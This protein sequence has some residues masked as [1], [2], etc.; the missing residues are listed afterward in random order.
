MVGE[1]GPEFFGSATVGAKGQ[2]VIPAGLRR[3]LNLEPGDKLIFF[4]NSEPS[5]RFSAVKPD[6]LLRMWE[7]LENR[8]KLLEKNG[9]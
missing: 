3:E 2:V 9:T 7:R 5:R 1:E 4:K 8:E 6:K